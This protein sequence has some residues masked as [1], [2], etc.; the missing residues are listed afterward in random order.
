MAENKDIKLYVTPL[1]IFLGII[2]FILIVL[3][4]SKFGFGLWSKHEDW[5]RLGDFFGGVL[6]PIIALVSLVL[7]LSTLKQNEK[8]LSQNK[9]ALEYNGEELKLTRQ[10]LSGS[11]EALQEQAKLLRKQTFEGTFFQLLSLHQDL[12]NSIDLYSKKTQYTTRG[13]DCFKTLYYKFSKIVLKEEENKGATLVNVIENII[14]KEKYKHEVRINIG[15][16]EYIRSSYK[17]FI[18]KN[19]SEVS[20]Y[21]KSLYNII[22][23]IDESNISEKEIY[24]N[25]IRAQLSTYEAALLFYN[26]I[27]HPGRVHFKKYIEKYSLFKNMQKDVLLSEKMH[28]KFY[29]KSAF[30]YQPKNKKV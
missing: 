23:F 4:I 26:E 14:I 6:N 9:E 21:F 22:K 8:A 3:Y 12:T 19:N 29:N 15:N 11:T 7:L 24:I 20:H 28:V 18:R 16:I 13:K 27:Y 2:L 25:T 5:A 30:N 1:L 17:K 10:E